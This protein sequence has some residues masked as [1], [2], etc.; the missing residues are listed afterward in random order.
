M[1]KGDNGIVTKTNEAKLESRAGNVD[2]EVKMW[3]NNNKMI[4]TQNEVTGESEALVSKEEMLEKLIQ[5][6]IVY[7]KEIDTER[8]IITIGGVK[9]DFGHESVEML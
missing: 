1:L 6:G 2:E 5:E 8:E 7:E 3:K 4:K 9:I